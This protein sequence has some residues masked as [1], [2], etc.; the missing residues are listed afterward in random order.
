MAASI[1]VVGLASTDMP[2]ATGESA[3]PQP[4][5]DFSSG[6]WP[7]HAGAFSFNI[8][9]SPTKQF[10]LDHREEPAVQPF[11]ALACGPRPEEELYDLKKDPQQLRN[12]VGQAPFREIRENLRRQLAARLRASREAID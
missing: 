1:T 6:E 3:S 8:D 7:T 2:V 10:L 12:V 9:P 5:I 4:S 11:F